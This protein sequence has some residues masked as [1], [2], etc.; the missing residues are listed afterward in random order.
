MV[1][2]QDEL[3]KTVTALLDIQ[4]EAPVSQFIL[5]T[6]SSNYS[7]GETATIFIP[8]SEGCKITIEIYH[9]K[10]LISADMIT[11]HEYETPYSFKVEE[12]SYPELT[13]NVVRKSYKPGAMSF[14]ENDK[15]SATANIEILK[16]IVPTS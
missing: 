7:E 5:T 14:D 3:D 4:G 13:V 2:D 1:L 15:V 12:G 16:A 9:R 8:S 6:D 11:G 10:K